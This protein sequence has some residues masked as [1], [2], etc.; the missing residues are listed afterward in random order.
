V[1]KNKITHYFTIC[2]L[3]KLETFVDVMRGYITHASPKHGTHPPS[4]FRRGLISF[5]PYYT[6]ADLISAGASEDADGEILYCAVGWLDGD[7]KN[8][9]DIRS[10]G[11]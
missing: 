10:V 7:D 4:P 6:R 2:S 8:P 5:Q 3:L 9:L 11:L 1:F